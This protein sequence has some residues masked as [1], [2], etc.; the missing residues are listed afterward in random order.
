MCIY[1][2]LLIQ[3]NGDVPPENSCNWNI[4]IDLYYE[5]W[6][7]IKLVQMYCLC[8]VVRNWIKLDQH[9]QLILNRMEIT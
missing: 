9:R 7:K 8:Q 1:I 2:L 6:T 4:V 5:S 3:H